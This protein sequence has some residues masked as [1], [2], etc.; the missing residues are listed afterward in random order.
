MALETELST[1]KR[2]L[3]TLLVNGAGKFVLIHG[4]KVAGVFD[5]YQDAIKEG[6]EKFKLEPFL[7]KQVN[8]FEQIH[9]MTRDVHPCHT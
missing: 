7:V 1:Y 3:P 8:A 9:F 6:Y 2:E 5:T 4:D